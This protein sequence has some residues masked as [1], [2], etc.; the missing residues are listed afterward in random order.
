MDDGLGWA[1]SG[2]IEINIDIGDGVRR[3]AKIATKLVNEDGQVHQSGRKSQ[4]NSNTGFDFRNIAGGSGRS[5]RWDL[6]RGRS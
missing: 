6:R 5:G 3:N 2:D 1:H 4:R